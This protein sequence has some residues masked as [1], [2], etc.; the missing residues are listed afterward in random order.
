LVLAKTLIHEPKVLLLDEPATGLDPI[1]RIELRTQLKILQ[2][3]NITIL[4]S[5]HIL[6]DLEDICTKVAL[7]GAGRNA[8][9]NENHGVIQLH[10]PGHAEES[11]VRTFEIGF[12]GDSMA[13]INILSTTAGA[14]LLNSHDNRLLVEIAGSDKDVSA[15]LRALVIGGLNVIRFDHRALGLEERYRLAFGET[16]L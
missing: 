14:R 9:D 16:R 12:V 4:I 10:T 11:M 8:V 13:A 7:I 6:S 5:S 3:E 15:V 1:A 2:A